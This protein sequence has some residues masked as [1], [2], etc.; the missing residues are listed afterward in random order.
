MAVDKTRR[1][2]QD[3]LEKAR[4]ARKE[5][6]KGAQDYYTKEALK[7]RAAQDRAKQ[8]KSAMAAVDRGVRE[9]TLA[10]RASARRRKID[11]A[12]DG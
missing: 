10:E 5:G 3:L 4:K 2:E 7:L 12:I 1:E 9:G 8:P 11:K 6:N